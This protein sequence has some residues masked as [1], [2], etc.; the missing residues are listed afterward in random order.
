MGHAIKSCSLN[1]KNVQD[2]ESAVIRDCFKSS[3]VQYDLM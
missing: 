1:Y 3:T 2:A